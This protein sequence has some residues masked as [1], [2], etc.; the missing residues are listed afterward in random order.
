MA[1]ARWAP[2]NVGNL[3]MEQIRDRNVTF[4]ALFS[5]I[6]SYRREAEEGVSCDEAGQVASGC[7]KTL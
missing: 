7:F 3:I 4:H 1:W 5:K 2:R 6:N